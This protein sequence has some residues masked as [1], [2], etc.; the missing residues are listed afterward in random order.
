[1]AVTADLGDSLDIHPK[2]KREVGERLALWALSKEYGHNVEYSGP[3]FLEADVQ[4]RDVLVRFIHG[5]KLQTSDG[6]M[7]RSFELAGE[8]KVFRA[9]KA[10]IDGDRIRV[11]SKEVSEPK[12][13]RYGWKPYSDGNLVNGE[14]LPASTF[15]AAVSIKEKK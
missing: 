12:W 4:N 5:E 14:G 9:A 13:V 3:L 6:E 1:M 2:R 15:G 7:P 10:T 11:R 8:D